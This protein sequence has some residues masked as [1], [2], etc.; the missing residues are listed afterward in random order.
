MV[1]PKASLYGGQS[2]DERKANK[3]K[4][5]RK[6]GGHSVPSAPELIYGSW[7]LERVSAGSYDGK[8]WV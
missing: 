2:V 1:S 7:K 8:D 6:E 4:G 3:E 5:G